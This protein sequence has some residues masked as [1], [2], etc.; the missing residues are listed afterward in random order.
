MRIIQ[1]T[2]KL[3]A[4]FLHTAYAYLREYNE[5]IRFF[6]IFVQFTYLISIN[7]EMQIT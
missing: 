4:Y 6:C 1:E 3:F 5:R 7:L 2:H